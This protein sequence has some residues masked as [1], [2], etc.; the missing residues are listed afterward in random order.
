M[1]KNGKASVSLKGTDGLDGG[2]I[3]SLCSGMDMFSPERWPAIAS[4]A[5]SVGA[6]DWQVRKWR[7]RRSVPGAWHLKL[8][9][10][11][12]ARGISLSSDELLSTQSQ[13]AA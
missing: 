12:V 5:K 7:V 10:V 6:K 11:C 8:L 3:M 13:R 4:A 2:D 1:P 9:G